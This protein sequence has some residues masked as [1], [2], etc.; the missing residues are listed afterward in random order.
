VLQRHISTR[1]KT[2]AEQAAAMRARKKR[3]MYVAPRI[4]SVTRP[5][6]PKEDEGQ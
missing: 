5:D 6:A 3:P 1:R 4:Q 2:E